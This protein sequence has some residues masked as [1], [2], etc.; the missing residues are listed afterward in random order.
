MPTHQP[1]NTMFDFNKVFLSVRELSLDEIE[2]K[3]ANGFDHLIHE[4][5]MPHHKL[6]LYLSLMHDLKLV[7]YAPE[8]KAVAITFFGARHSIIHVN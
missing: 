2:L 8:D 1:K 7:N 6:D 5:G 4:T 3:A